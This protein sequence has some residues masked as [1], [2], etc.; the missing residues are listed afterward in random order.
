[1][2]LTGFA[3]ISIIITALLVYALADKSQ[4][5]Q[6]GV[7]P[8]L[9]PYKKQ[10]KT[11]VQNKQLTKSE[12]ETRAQKIINTLPKPY[13]KRYQLAFSQP[14]ALK[15]YGRV[16]D[17]YG[18]PVVNAGIWQNGGSAFLMEGGGRGYART[19]EEGY[20]RID[21]TGVSLELGGV[22]HPEIDGVNYPKSGKGQLR[23]YNISAR[24]LTYPNG[25]MGEY[26]LE[27]YNTKENAF[28][29][30]TWRMQ[31]YEGAVAGKTTL[32]INADGR[33]YTLKFDEHKK[34]NRDNLLREG[35]YE[36]D[37]R[38]SC[39][40][41]I[42]AYNIEENKINYGDWRFS[43]TP[44]D[45]GI[46]ETN[47]LYMNMAPGTDYKASLLIDMKKGTSDYERSVVNKRYYF[48]AHNDKTYGMIY[49]YIKPYSTEDSCDFYIT[50]Y[51]YNS[52]G[53]RNL[54][55]KRDN[56]SQQLLPVNPSVQKLANL[57]EFKFKEK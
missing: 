2:K 10:L 35:E 51:R 21:T 34:R 1:M 49:A 33:I 55:L 14:P 54:E 56:S 12:K 7:N 53:S 5:K 19:D 50:E 45:G 43:I 28:L 22:S 48:K 30:K 46:Q 6:S 11:L 57:G 31:G 23:L 3:F 42:H 29:I 38:V 24:F 52:T 44:I 47:D 32:E 18:Q 8:E 27:N 25:P 16:V 13:R 4:H 37:L 36:G 26:Y 20:F 15:M 9:L 41:D 17:Q 39:T 40:R